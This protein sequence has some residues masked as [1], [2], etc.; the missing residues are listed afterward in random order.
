MSEIRTYPHGAPNW[1]DAA[2]P[3]PQA[4]QDFYRQLF[5]WTFTTVAPPGAPAA[6]RCGRVQMP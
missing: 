1:I 3:D 2:R 6:E 4:A 5:G